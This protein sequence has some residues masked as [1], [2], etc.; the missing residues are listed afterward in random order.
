MTL[1]SPDVANVQDVRERASGRPDHKRVDWKEVA[2]R[3]AA[4]HTSAAPAKKA[5]AAARKPR[6]DSRK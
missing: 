6:A 1:R 4:S 5:R 2:A 3:V